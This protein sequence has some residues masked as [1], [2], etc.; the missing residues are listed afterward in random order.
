MKFF[1][2]YAG[3]SPGQLENELE[4]GGWLMTAASKSHLFGDI[5][6]LWP[7][8]MKEISDAI[9]AG[10]NPKVIPEDPTTN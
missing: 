4:E 7:I 3:W 6:D 1:V 8:L 10:L 9:F 2:G 5:E